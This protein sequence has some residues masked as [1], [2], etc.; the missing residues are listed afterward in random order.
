MFLGVDTIWSWLIPLV[1]SSAAAFFLL[2]LGKQAEL[3]RGALSPLSGRMG[4]A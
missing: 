2:S 3:F 4:K 1:T